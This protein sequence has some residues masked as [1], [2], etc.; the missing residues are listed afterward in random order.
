[1]TLFLIAAMMIPIQSAI[2][3]IVQMV[4]AMARDQWII[5]KGELYRAKKDGAMFEGEL[6]LKT[7]EKGALKE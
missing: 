6:H 3:P 4:G 2:V 7:D 1:M 5:W